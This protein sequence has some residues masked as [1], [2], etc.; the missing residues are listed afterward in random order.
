MNEKQKAEFFR[1]VQ[2]GVPVPKAKDK[3]EEKER[4]LVSALIKEISEHDSTKR[5]YILAL[6][7][8]DPKSFEGSETKKELKR[9]L[10]S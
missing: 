6:K 4:N 9:K 8:K 3:V 5:A 10:S 7:I 1:L 2:E